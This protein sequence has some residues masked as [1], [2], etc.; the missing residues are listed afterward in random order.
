[1]PRVGQNYFF[2][3]VPLELGVEFARAPDSSL[4]ACL[5][6]MM[7][8]SEVDCEAIAREAALLSRIGRPR[9]QKRFQNPL[10]GVLGQLGRFA[11]CGA[12]ALSRCCRSPPEPLVGRSNG[13]KQPQQPPGLDGVH[14]FFQDGNLRLLRESSKISERLISSR[15]THSRP[16]CDRRV[17]QD[18]RVLVHHCAACVRSE[19]WFIGGRPRLSGRW[20]PC[21]HEQDDS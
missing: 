6:T 3:V 17:V 4:W 20:R 8:I 19:F 10:F 15:L 5:C 7:C 16:C 2:R 9:F 18:G 1:M 21:C 12:E 14:G 11:P 13:T